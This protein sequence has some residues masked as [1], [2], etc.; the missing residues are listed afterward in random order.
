MADA[1]VTGAPA[2]REAGDTARADRATAEAGAAQEGVVG[3]Q[4]TEFSG[5]VVALFLTQVLAAG[6][7]IFSGILL[8][9]LLG[10][11]QKGE[12]YILTLIPATAMVLLQL[13]LPRAFGYY[14]ARGITSTVISK[15][16]VLSGLLT[17][18]AVAG[19][20]VVLPF[21]QADVL[22]G[23]PLEE[24]MFAFLSFPLAINGAFTIAIVMGRKGV[25]WYAGVNILASIAALVLL[26]VLLLVIGPSVL[27]AVAAYVLT[28]LVQT[29]ASAVGARRVTAGLHATERVTYRGLFRYGLPFY[30][31]SLAVFFSYRVDAYLIAFIMTDAA[32]A[33]GYYSLA[34]GLAEIVFFFPRAVS[35]LYFPHVAGSPRQE[36]DLQVAATSRVTLLV[37]GISALLMAPAATLMI[38]L[39]LPAYVPALPALYLLL[40]GVVAFSVTFV[41]NGYLTGIDRPG[42]TSTVSLVSLV[43]NV[44]AN[45]ILIPRFG[46]AGAASASLFSYSLSSV[47]LSIVAARLTGT[48]FHRFWIPGLSD[49]RYTLGTTVGLLGRLR[50]PVSIL[51]GSAGAR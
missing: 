37:T 27:A 51:T 11:T 6:I 20:F 40:P 39:I 34:V 21:L 5:G 17:L 48:R 7:G 14:T 23:I 38:I 8:A 22:R 13:G 2:P 19:L 32:T 28:N 43:A 49:V 36:S 24:I 46:I 45:L 50:H 30:P 4:G 18:V 25:R 29:V 31:G 47:L 42:I 33:L 3:R 35:T 9:R 10:P 44:I 26:A 12:Y 41:V 1:D 16:F 15:A